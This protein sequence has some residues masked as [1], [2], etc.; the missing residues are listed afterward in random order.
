MTDLLFYKQLTTLDKDKHA[1][2]KLARTT[3][4]RFAAA[5]NSLPVVAVEFV[6]AHKEY[7]IVFVKGADGGFLPVALVGLR[8]NENLCLGADGRWDGHYVPA[9]VRRYPFAPADAGNNQML[10]CFDETAACLG[11]GEGEPLFVDG[12]QG[13]V[14]QQAL[15][16]LQE[17]Q[18][19]ALRTQAFCQH[20]ADFNLLMESNAE[21]RMNDGTSHRLSGMYVV[22][23]KRLQVL[24]PDKVQQLFASGELSLIYAHLMSLGN[25]Q[26][27]VDRLAARTTS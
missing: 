26:R 27:L 9:F 2:L 4:Y 11:S 1:A 17:Y 8:D 18:G 25:L 14:L 15:T 20:L 3:D 10:V 23:E 12:A 13:P 7:P 24:D 16:L 19:Q 5:T 21:A 22:D 6:E